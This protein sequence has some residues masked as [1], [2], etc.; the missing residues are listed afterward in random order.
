MFKCHIWLKVFPVTLYWHILVYT[1]AARWGV[2][3]TAVSKNKIFC[4][5]VSFYDIQ[6][7]VCGFS[8]KIKKSSDA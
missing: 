5:Y 8:K 6:A 4:Y 1:S 2:K 3:P 7:L